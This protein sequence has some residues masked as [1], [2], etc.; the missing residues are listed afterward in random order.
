[1]F[2]FVLLSRKCDC[3]CDVHL[4]LFA[5]SARTTYDERAYLHAAIRCRLPCVVAIR[6]R[7]PCVVARAVLVPPRTRDLFFLHY[8][9]AHLTINMHIYTLQAALRRCKGSVSA[10]THAQ[11]KHAHAHVSNKYAASLAGK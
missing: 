1:M 7:L 8:P 4:C 11:L 9:L 6:C 5:L 10:A 3:S 2:S